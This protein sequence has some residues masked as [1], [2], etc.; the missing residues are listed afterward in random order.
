[1]TP[2]ELAAFASSTKSPKKREELR[3]ELEDQRKADLRDLRR[4]GRNDALLTTILHHPFFEP[5]LV[6][7]IPTS[8]SKTPDKVSPVPAA[9]APASPV[10]PASAVA[11]R[12]RKLSFRDAEDATELLVDAFDELGLENAEEDLRR[13][14]RLSGRRVTTYARPTKRARTSESQ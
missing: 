1:V 7:E 3:T 6:D 2:E 11:K 10:T 14:D 12:K 9:K 5:L 4:L 13:S 8:F